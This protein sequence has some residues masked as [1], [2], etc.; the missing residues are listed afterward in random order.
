MIVIGEIARDKERC[1]HGHRRLMRRLISLY[2]SG[3]VVSPLILHAVIVLSLH[4]VVCSD[5]IRPHRMNHT[6]AAYC[7][8]RRTF[9]GL[10]VCPCVGHTDEPSKS[11]RTDR[12]AV[13]E[14]RLAWA[15]ENTWRIRLNDLCAL[16]MRLYGKL[17]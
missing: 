17:L 7:Y 2:I 15:H 8:T 10:L 3:L 1:V 13:W 6:D 12:N 4:L 14:G 5:I 9:R 16:A 11:G